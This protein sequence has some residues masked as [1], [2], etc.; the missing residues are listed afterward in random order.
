MT[1]IEALQAAKASPGK[2]G[3]R[4]K[5]PP[6]GSHH[7]LVFIQGKFRR[8]RHARYKRLTDPFD[9]YT[10][11]PS[12]IP[13]LILSEWETVAIPPGEKESSRDA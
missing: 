6:P 11:G 13:E 12:I 8:E 1:C 10:F 7:P 2:V 9:K 3:A 5:H 4:P